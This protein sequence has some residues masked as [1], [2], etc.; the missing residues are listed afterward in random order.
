MNTNHNALSIATFLAA[1][2]A[3]AF[4]PFN[5]PA[6]A[7]AVTVIGVFAILFSDYGRRTTTLRVPATV[8]PLSLGSASRVPLR[9]AA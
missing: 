8:V 3:L 1:I 2:A 5:A 7:A 9:D 4:L 6:A